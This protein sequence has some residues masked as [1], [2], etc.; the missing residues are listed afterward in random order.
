MYYCLP[1]SFSVSSC[2]QVNVNSNVQ[3]AMNSLKTEQDVPKILV[4]SPQ[5]SENLDHLLAKYSDVFPG[6]LPPGLPSCMRCAAWHR[7]SP[8]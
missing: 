1:P 4:L 6:D 5:A 2:E 7:C 8:G 3:Y